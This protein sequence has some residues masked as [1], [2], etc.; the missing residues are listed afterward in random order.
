MIT[1]IS[2]IIG[3]LGLVIGFAIS[4]VFVSSLTKNKIE[5]AKANIENKKREQFLLLEKENSQ[6][7]EKASRIGEYEQ[8]IIQTEEKLNQKIIENTQ[9]VKQKAEIETALQKERESTVEKLELLQNS[10]NELV[11][12][13]ENLSNKIL[14]EKSKKFTQTNKDN[15]EGILSPLKN[16]FA[17]FK[18]RVNDVYKNDSDDRTALKTQ[19][20]GLRELN[21]K[22]GK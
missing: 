11:N 15:I 1:A 21:E 2:F 18:K 3:I 8:K 20:D 4:F 5:L 19:I 13:F 10:K 14:E 9:L 12:Q 6:L 17:E 16:E 7:K 22:L